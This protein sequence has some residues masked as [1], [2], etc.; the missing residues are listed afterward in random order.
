M[1][2]PVGSFL[3]RK[4]NRASSGDFWNE[5]KISSIERDCFFHSPVQAA[6]GEHSLP[7]MYPFVKKLPTGQSLWWIHY[8]LKYTSVVNFV[9]GPNRPD[10]EDGGAFQQPKR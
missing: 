3:T 6:C 4:N 1:L 8:Y 9:G 7:V 10:R 5:M 2:R